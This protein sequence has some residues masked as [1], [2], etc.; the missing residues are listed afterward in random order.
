M[1]Q[2]GQEIGPYALLKRIGRGG[3][4]EVWL[5]ERRAKFVTTKV[6]VKLPFQEQV[7]TDAIKNEAILWEQ[8]SG[9]PNVISMIEANEYD[10]QV[11]IVSEFASEGSLGDL[12]E[13]ERSIPFKKAVELI[14]GVLNGLEFLHSK[15][16]IHR[17]LKPGNILL[18][19]DT[20]RLADF[21]LSRVIKTTSVSINL[22]G[23]PS[24]M[25]P[26]AFE[27]KRNVQTDIWSVGVI[28]YEMLNGVLPFPQTNLPD[29]FGAT[30]RD[31]PG[32]FVKSVPA[33]L[34]S[35]VLKALAKTPGGRYQTAYAMRDAL[36]DFLA[37]VYHH[38]AVDTIPNDEWPLLSADTLPL[39]STP[40]LLPTNLTGSST[41]IVGRE[42]EI[43]ELTELLLR[44]D[45]GLIT[46]TG[47]GGTGKTTLS[48]ALAGGLLDKFADGVFLVQLDTI[49]NADLVI[50]T[51]AE[52]LG[53]KEAGARPVIDI[54]KDHL[55]NKHI[56]LI[57][58]NFE[59]LTDAAPQIADLLS[60]SSDLKILITSRT[61]LRLSAEREY[62]VPP[63]PVPSDPAS[64]SFADLSN[65]ASVKLFV[66]RSQKSKHDFALTNENARTI[67]EICRRLD[68]LPLAIELA[69]ARV[70]VLSP[71]AILTKLENRLDLLTGGSTD[72]PS[73]QKTMRSS[74]E[75]SYDLLTEDEKQLFRHL[76][77]FSGGF[78]VEA[79]ET[80]C[81]KQTMGVSGAQPS[82]KRVSNRS[83]TNDDLAQRGVNRLLPA[84][85][86]ILDGVTSL[87]DKNLIVAHEQPD[88]ELRFRMLEVVHEFALDALLLNEQ[89]DTMFHRH[90]KYF[91]ALSQAAEPH[92]RAA[93]SA[94]WL[95]CLEIENDNLRAALS[96][97]LENDAA[98]AASLA[99][100]L[101]YFWTRHD[102]LREGRKWLKAALESAGSDVPSN[103][104][105]KLL[106]GLG[107][108]AR[109]Q[110][111]FE[112]AKRAHEKGL[113]AGRETENDPQIALAS[114]GLAAVLVE[115]GDLKGAEK[116]LDDGLELGRKLGDKFGIAVTFSML[117]DLARLKC[118]WSAA[119]SHF[120]A[121]LAISME[122][123]DKWFMT[124]TINNLGFVAFNDG[125]YESARTHFKKALKL[126]QEV[127]NTIAISYSLDGLAAFALKS[128]EPR[129][130][131]QLSGAAE[132]LRESIQCEME[133]AERIFRDAY[134]TDLSSQLDE[135]A[136][137]N[138]RNYGRDLIMEDLIALCLKD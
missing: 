28:L 4:G 36:T 120:E 18:Q 34:Q 95:D 91:L 115:L 24:Y 43:S 17:D 126:S 78:T 42:K 6:A 8:A 29:L 97:S 19:G 65:Y 23:T 85:Y 118:D 138:A 98:I 109:L 100:A 68:G 56:L 124:S 127:D 54:L 57:L 104:R 40:A 37:D 31:E 60:I 73:R 79:A 2:A 12:L 96:W 75:W 9:H 13:K 131:A 67:A 84:S 122:L 117:G 103:V 61:L 38:G 69:A 33:K 10:G 116:L 55:V 123:D 134:L 62:V 90:A 7:D 106:N 58:D 107:L 53:V 47:T 93:K 27:R 112:T 110:G 136:L 64:F 59:Q 22:S 71:Q 21:G 52:R 72:M 32:P 3:F 94:E 49:T 16:I 130:A 113:E 30:T 121:S 51:V 15:N 45:V 76:S 87:V 101:R 83:L 129:L 135:N 99:A 102:H 74:L 88:G 105:F 80:V 25:A 44:E 26:E 41:P 92:L 108:T 11:V 128:D 119:R 81:R 66:N 5:A 137:I 77:V 20:P 50:S 70:K 14:L 133:P 46:L 63:L 114:R 1:F 86:D 111:D 39:I 132:K 125:D 35:I 89:A 48:R 82:N